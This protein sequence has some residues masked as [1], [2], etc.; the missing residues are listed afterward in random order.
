MFPYQENVVIKAAFWIRGL[1]FIWPQIKSI[2]KH[3]FTHSDQTQSFL[4][5][6]RLSRQFQLAVLREQWLGFFP[7]VGTPKKYFF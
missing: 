4:I 1:E 7:R 5:M 3:H 6:Q 2:S